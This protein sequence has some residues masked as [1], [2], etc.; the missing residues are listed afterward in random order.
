MEHRK[1]VMLHKEASCHGNLNHVTKKKFRTFQASN[2]SIENLVQS[3]F[4][5]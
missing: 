1:K 2:G 4:T 5:L 3:H